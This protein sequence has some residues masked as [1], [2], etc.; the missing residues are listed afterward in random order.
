MFKPAGNLRCKMS[1]CL[2]C[3]INAPHALALAQSLGTRNK[4]R[5]E[6]EKKINFVRI[7]TLEIRIYTINIFY[8]SHCGD[9]LTSIKYYLGTANLEL[10]SRPLLQCDCLVEAFSNHYNN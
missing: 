4:V 10:T 5:V 3:Q 2:R 9:I 7:Y 1:L 8:S 6:A